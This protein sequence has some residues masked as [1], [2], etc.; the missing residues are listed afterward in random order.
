MHVGSRSDRGFG[1]LL[2]FLLQLFFHFREQVFLLS[3]LLGFKRLDFLGEMALPVLELPDLVL[4]PAA[5]LAARNVFDLAVVADE[6]AGAEGSL[7]GFQ[8]PK[9]GPWKV[10]VQATD[11]TPASG[12]DFA[13][14]V[15]FVGGAKLASESSTLL[16]QLNQP[17]QIQAGVSLNGQSLQISKAQA[18]IRDP[19]GK[20]ET[21]DFPT[22]Q[23]VSVNWTPQEAGT[24][25]V[26][27][28]VT[29]QAPDGSSIERTDFLAIEVQPNPGKARVTFNLLAVIALVLL[30]IGGILFGIIWLIR[31]A[32]R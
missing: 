12:T 29:A 24:H 25:S 17:V 13:V 27:I 5:D 19:Q 3:G 14:S 20:V 2:D 10:T 30:V 28:V 31:R 32:R 1:F 18:V 11:A 22:G 7:Y 6:Q 23:N 15:Y 16:P 26:D 8:N 9:P 4:Q 21:I